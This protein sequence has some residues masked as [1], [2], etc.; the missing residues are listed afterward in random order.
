MPIKLQFISPADDGKRHFELIDGN[1]VGGYQILADLFLDQSIQ[2]QAHQPELQSGMLH[3]VK[4]NHPLCLIMAYGVNG[5]P[6]INLM[7]PY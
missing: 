2:L 5:P 4:M 6:V 1:E 3:K 7:S